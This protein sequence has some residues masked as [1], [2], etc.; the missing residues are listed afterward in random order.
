MC[1]SRWRWSMAT[2]RS[3]RER[4]LSPAAR[5]CF[6]QAESGPAMEE[7][8]RW[9]LRQLDERLVEPNSAL[10]GAISYMLKH[11]QERITARYKHY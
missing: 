6:H 7:L 10:G 5:R 1:W 4:N 11:W 8:H 2:T 9:L 3:R